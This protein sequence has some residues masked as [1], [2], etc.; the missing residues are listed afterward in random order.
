MLHRGAAAPGTAWP[1]ARCSPRMAAP[2]SACSASE[3]LP[4]VACYYRTPNAQWA[5]A[6]SSSSP[7]QH[8]GS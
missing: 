2:Q 1:I 4:L 7:V 5:S 8:M 3:H 6:Q